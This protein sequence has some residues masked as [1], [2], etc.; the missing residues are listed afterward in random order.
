LHT[1]VPVIDG[2]VS[3]AYESLV[4]IIYIYIKFDLSI[5]DLTLLKRLRDIELLIK[6]PS[7]SGTDSA[8]QWIYALG[9][10]WIT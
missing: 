8:H 9:L 3:I 4:H 2:N 10:F 5:S 7:A 6:I 1:I